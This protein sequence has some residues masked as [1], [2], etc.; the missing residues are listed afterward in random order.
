[1]HCVRHLMH[2]ARGP[3]PICHTIAQEQDLLLGLFFGIFAALRCTN[4]K[5]PQ[6]NLNPASACFFHCSP[7]IQLMR[8]SLIWY[9]TS[10]ATHCSTR[11]VQS[12]LLRLPEDLL[13]MGFLLFG[14]VFFCQAFSTGFLDRSSRSAR[15]HSRQGSETE[16][17]LAAVGR[18]EMVAY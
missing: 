2:C 12:G 14:Q 1:M 13:Q 4:R 15:P 11:S 7:S 5:L 16:L 17:I 8:S 9:I 3:N 10:W 6:S 18:S